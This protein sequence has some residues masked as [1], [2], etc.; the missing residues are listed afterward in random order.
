MQA[1][2]EY[3]VIATQVLHVTVYGISV[4]VYI[5]VLTSLLCL[6]CTGLD[7]NDT[8]ITGKAWLGQVTIMSSQCIHFPKFILLKQKMSSFREEHNVLQPNTDLGICEWLQ[9][10]HNGDEMK[11]KSKDQNKEHFPSIQVHFF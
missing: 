10:Q 9:H 3:A 4:E 5:R 1:G 2:Q 8:A 11:S 7:T 6:R